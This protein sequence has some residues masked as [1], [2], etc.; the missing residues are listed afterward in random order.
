MKILYLA[1]VFLSFSIVNATAQCNTCTYVSSSQAVGTTT[2]VTILKPTGVVENDVMI[3]AIHDGW[4]NS[5][6]AITPPSGW[7]L[8]NNTSNNGPGCGSS[9]TSIQ[10]ATFYKVAGVSEPASYT[11][12]GI[13]NQ[14]Y[15]GGI[16]AYS[17]VNTSNPINASS[18]FGGQELC[19]NIVANSVTTTASCTRL[20]AV[21]F[22]SVNNSLNN[23]V[24]NGSLTERVDVGT[25]GNHIWGN[26]NLEISDE[27]MSTSGTTG[28]KS[29][30]LNGC[31]G[32]SWVTGGQLI[33]LE[34]NASSSVFENG[35]LSNIKVI[36]N[37]S[38]GVFEISMEENFSQTIEL[39]M[40]DCFGRM[41]ST[42]KLFDKKTTIDLSDQTKG[43]YVLKLSSKEGVYIQKMIIN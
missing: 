21:F 15:V 7:T 5:G 41:I 25:T 31:S 17:D 18:T 10:L 14:Q 34:C 36:P 30:Y 39:K 37:P 6:S 8:I 22:C 28:N 12:T 3:A 13:T 29:A 16:V 35:F 33:A 9:N 1:L 42:K 24:P 26:E 38:K 27:L 32:T 23:I 11:F 43:I 4:C 40:Y 19:T 20:V 2:D